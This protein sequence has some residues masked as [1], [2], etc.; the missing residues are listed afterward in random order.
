LVFFFLRQLTEYSFLYLQSSKVQF[1]ACQ[2]LFIL[3]DINENTLHLTL[4]NLCYRHAWTLTW[5]SSVRSKYDGISILEY[6]NW[7]TNSK[8]PG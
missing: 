2:L 7:V 1:P 8:E 5:I 6:K 4:L 3:F